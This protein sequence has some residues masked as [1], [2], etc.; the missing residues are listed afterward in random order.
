VEVR[1]SSCRHLRNSTLC[2][3][4]MWEN[5]IFHV[6]TERP[7]TIHRRDLCLGGL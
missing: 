1:S 5:P 7:P 3:P 2:S 4:E 6:A